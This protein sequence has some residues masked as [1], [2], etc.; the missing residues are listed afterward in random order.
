M[1]DPLSPEQFFLHGSRHAFKPGAMLTPE[2]AAKAGSSW[3]AGQTD[4]HVY[5]TPDI[6]AARSFAENGMGP[7]RNPDAAPNVYHVRPTGPFEVDTDEPEFP[8][9]KTQHPVEVIRRVWRGQ[10]G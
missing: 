8:S 3:G 7:Q 9:L 2:G 6:N 1:S 10:R 5:F 4:N